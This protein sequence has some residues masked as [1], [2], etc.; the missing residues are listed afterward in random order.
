M[1]PWSGVIQK[2]SRPTADGQ[3]PELLVLKVPG[4]SG[5]IQDL[6]KAAWKP[7]LNR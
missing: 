1:A 2:H 3:H 5:A 7:I 4:R 6:R